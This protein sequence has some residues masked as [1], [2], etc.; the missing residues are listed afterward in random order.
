MDTY[1]LYLALAEESLYDC[2]QPQKRDIWEKM[3]END[4]RDSFKADAK[5]KFL[6]RTCCSIHKKRNLCA[7]KCYVYVAKLN[8]AK[9]TSQTS[10]NSVVKVCTK[11]SGD[12]T[13]SKYRRVLDEAVNFTSTN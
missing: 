9:T 13:M 12:G 5:S 7:Q 3:G 6:P 2:I 8:A 1:S 4:C 10:S 11:E